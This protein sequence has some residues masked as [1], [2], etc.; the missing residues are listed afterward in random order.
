MVVR[1]IPMRR[2]IATIACLTG[3]YVGS[4][5]GVPQGDEPTDDAADSGGQVDD[6][7]DPEPPSACGETP[8]RVVA[9]RLNRTEYNNTL[10]D[11]FTGFDVGTP[12][13]ELPDDV[14]GAIGLTVSD[15]FLEK[16]EQVVTELAARAVDEGFI[17]CDPGVEPHACARE[18]FGPFMKRAWRRP[19]EPG[20]VDNVLRYIDIVAAAPGETDTFEEAIQLSIQHVLMA[21][22]FLFRFEEIAD[23]DST[24]PQPLGDYEIAS[25]LSYFIYASMPD[26]ALLEAADA[27]TLTDPEELEAQVDRML[28]DPKGIALVDRIA[29]AWLTADRVDILNP[30]PELYPTFDDDLRESMK[31][32]L[33][34]FL[35][36]FLEEDRS[37]RDMLDADFTYVNDRLAAHYG[38]PNADTFSRD[39]TRVSLDALPERGGLLTMGAVLAATSVPHN[40]ET[41]VVSETN[42]IVRG[43][44][45]LE[46]F[47]CFE[48]P[49]PPPDLDV[50]AVQEDA[51]K[52]IPDTAPRKE[53]EGFRQEMQP[54]AS[55]HLYLDPMGFAMEHFDVTGAWRTEDNLG[56]AVDATGMLLGAGENGEFDGA[57][58]LGTLLKEDPR[59]SACIT[60][61]LLKLAVQRA[62]QPDDDC[63][64]DELSERSDES[65]NGLRALVLSIVKSP[66]FVQ[67]QGEAP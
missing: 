30:N 33:S 15:Y 5:S 49:P 37:F 54:C 19:V 14:E 9:V 34:L 52:D 40:D 64:T 11:L 61:A 16:H 45:I 55:C 42:I 32:E 6:D 3:C 10:R 36:E 12:A 24:E 8:G 58:E 31:Q 65:G 18:I 56:T 23:P 4:Q 51:Q 50:N 25:R 35:Q 27:G 2:A 39:F 48:L 44:F 21:P 7:A 28:A 29:N 67:Q 47:P 60:E 38:I 66:P 41:A 17:T 59:L 22:N 57:H 62:L 1:G 63:V 46:T 26:D 53:R 13:D 20:E 43:K